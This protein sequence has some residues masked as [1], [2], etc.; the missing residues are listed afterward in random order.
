MSWS[1]WTCSFKY[2]HRASLFSTVTSPAPQQWTEDQLLSCKWNTACRCSLKCHS[3][4]IPSLVLFY[5][6][7][8][9]SII[10][11]WIKTYNWITRFTIEIHKKRSALRRNKGV[12]TRYVCVCVS[13]TDG[14]QHQ[15][16]WHESSCSSLY[17]NLFHTG[18]RTRTTHAERQSS[19]C[20]DVSERHQQWRQMSLFYVPSHTQ[21][22]TLTALCRKLLCISGIF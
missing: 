4:R 8:L 6:L 22:H 3:S 13:F 15:V 21:T 14:L 9:K 2:N 7:S 20:V 5:F 19:P 10:Y 17:A 18:A 16:L 1:V 12:K 11:L